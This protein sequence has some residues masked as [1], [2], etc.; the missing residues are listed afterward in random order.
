MY[1]KQTSENKINPR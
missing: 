1:R